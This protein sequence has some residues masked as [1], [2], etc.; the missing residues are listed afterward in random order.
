MVKTSDVHFDPER[1]Q[2][3]LAAQGSHGITSALGDVKKWDS[4]LAGVVSVWKDPADGKT[5]V[6]NGHHRLDLAQKM[7]V[8]KVHVKYLDAPNA[9]AARAKGAMVNIAE[10]RGSAIDAAKF[11][12]DTGVTKEHAQ[13]SGLSMREHTANQGLA[14]AGLEPHAFG[15]V[16][17][18]EITPARAAIIG[19]SGLSHEQQRQ[20]VKVLH[21]P[22]NRKLTDGTV[23][24]LADSAREAGSRTKTTRDLFGSNEEEESLFVHRAKVE[25]GIK[26]SLAGDKRLF[27]L[28]S[29][30]KAAQALEERGR[31]SI[32]VAE[33]GKVGAEAASVLG[34]FDQLKHRNPHISRP[35]NRA[36]ERIANGENA[37]TVEADTRRE[38]SEYIKDVLEGRADA[39]AA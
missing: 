34:V 20:L 28:V 5:Y 8:D 19:G 1:F 9:Q 16:I 37:K 23:K 24:N 4:E 14:M 31:S 27:S 38:V 29:K 17:N 22:Q 39:F 15:R 3:K 7:G 36:A 30:S 21:K 11:F 2:Y 25:D 32:D 6:V 35:L 26:R 13:A 12:R 33:T 10:G 18:G